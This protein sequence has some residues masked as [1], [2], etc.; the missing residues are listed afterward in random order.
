MVQCAKT[1]SKKE[2]KTK[3]RSASEVAK[4]LD[5]CR[6]PQVR[7]SVLVFF[8][9]EGPGSPP[10]AS[11]SD[12]ECG[13]ITSSSDSSSSE[14]GPYELVPRPAPSAARG[15][16]E[17]PVPAPAGTPDGPGGKKGI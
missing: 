13:L 2:N 1:T 7:E 11:D 9:D 10:S 3:R 4:C 6:W 5:Q 15:G 16:T 14:T 12:S 17:G 8:L